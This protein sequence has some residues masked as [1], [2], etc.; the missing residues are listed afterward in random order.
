MYNFD[1]KILFLT[2]CI[3]E[4]YVNRSIMLI[5]SICKFT[6]SRLKI[7]TDFPE[8][9]IELKNFY[10]DQMLI[11]DIKY[12]N[13]KKEINQIFNYHLKY[14]PFFDSIEDPEQSLF[15]I[16]C[17]SF[18]FGW[19]KGYSR[20]VSGQENCLIRRCRENLSS[21]ES[22]KNLLEIKQEDYIKSESNIILNNINQPLILENAFIIN[23]GFEAINFIKKWKE[24]S[25]FAISNEIYPFL[26][27]VEIAIALN[28]TNLTVLNLDSKMPMID[29]LRT[30]HYDK[31]IS[32]WI[33]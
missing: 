24:I 26:E 15:Y 18:L 6:S 14:I 17:D 22:L 19:D 10:G 25:D 31:I 7:Y 11:I 23:K 16:D 29:S 20:Y 8:R 5:Q 12:D 1:K 13:Y 9:F 3:G 32:T 28:E 33:I 30:L 2:I 21:C 27:A 4:E